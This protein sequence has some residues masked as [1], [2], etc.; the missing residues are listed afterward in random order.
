MA[1]KGAKAQRLDGS[2]Q[3]TVKPQKGKTFK[4]DVKAS[5]TIADVK[6]KIQDKYDIPT[7]QQNLMYR[8]EVLEN[9]RTLSDI[10]VA[11]CAQ[12]W[13]LHWDRDDEEHEG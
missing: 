9:C 4:L 3:I 13:F 8:G 11:E 10:K 6:A 2:M 7:D 12:P 5:D 1:P